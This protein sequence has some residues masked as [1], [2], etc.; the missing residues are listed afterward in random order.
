MDILIAI[1][2]S[3]NAR[4][5]LDTTINLLR[6]SLGTAWLLHV[7][8]PDPDFVGYEADPAVMRKQV[9]EEFHREHRQL[10]GMAEE[11]RARSLDA[12][13]LLIQ[14]ETVKTII[15]QAD[16]LNVDLIVVGSHAHGALYHFLLGNVTKGVLKQ[17]WRPVLVMPIP[18]DK[19]DN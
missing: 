9:A 11:L 12:K 17:S 2:L 6:D 1:D 3:E 14:G 4:K 5:M 16:K 8:E 10:H 15:Q 18:F 19:P 7:A 13:A